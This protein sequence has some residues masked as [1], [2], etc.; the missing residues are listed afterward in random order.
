MEITPKI[1]NNGLPIWW[2]DPG[3]HWSDRLFQMMWVINKVV[4]RI[5]MLRCRD[6]MRGFAKNFSIW[7]GIF[8]LTIPDIESVRGL[9][10]FYVT[11]M[12]L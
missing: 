10:G 1:G 2:W 5:G 8:S 9:V 7:R 11:K 4:V 12:P 3:I 6:V